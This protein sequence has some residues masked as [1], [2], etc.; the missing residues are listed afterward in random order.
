MRTIKE[1]L[2]N[3]LE[4]Q[5]QEAEIQGLTKIA[6]ALTD[7]LEKNSNIRNNND[8]YLYSSI[9]FKKDI[10]NK[11]WDI[12]IRSSDYY[13][14]RFDAVEANNIVEKYSND[15]IKELRLKL[16]VEHGVGAYEPEVAGELQDKI[17]LEID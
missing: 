15:L 14:K 16:G 1:S 6:A 5:A 12:I 11:I 13:N 7:Q 4:A 10:E 2:L 9:D 8:F 17:V 3:N